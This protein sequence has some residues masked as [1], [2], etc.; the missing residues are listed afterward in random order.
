MTLIHS[1]Q[2]THSL[3]DVDSIQ[4][5]IQNSNAGSSH[6][7]T[8]RYLH[9]FSKIL[10]CCFDFYRFFRFSTASTNIIIG[11]Q[12]GRRPLYARRHWCAT[13]CCATRV[14][15]L[16]CYQWYHLSPITYHLSPITYHLSP[17]TYHL[18]PIT[19]HLSPITYHLSPI[20]FQAIC[21]RYLGT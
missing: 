3:T 12:P 2:L 17:I 20:R 4:F 9:A 6:C 10:Q 11:S 19:Y 16:W 8:F 14:C 15:Y 1:F 7:Y 18:S 21:H 13:R 5:S